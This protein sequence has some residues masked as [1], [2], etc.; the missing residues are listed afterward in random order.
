MLLASDFFYGLLHKDAAYVSPFFIRVQSILNHEWNNILSGTQKKHQ[1]TREYTP[2]HHLENSDLDINVTIQQLII[3]IGTIR[4]SF[5]YGENNSS[6]VLQTTS[7]VFI[8]VFF[9]LAIL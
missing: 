6:H 1:D 3:P 5:M 4:H 8:I 2:V 7:A 9:F